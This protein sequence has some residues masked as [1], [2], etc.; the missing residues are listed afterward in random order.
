MKVTISGDLKK[1]LD[2]ETVLAGKAIRRGVEAAGK[3]VQDELR[4]QVAGGGFASSR[5]LSNAWRL[6]V[7]SSSGGSSL[8]PAAMIYTQAPDIID[9]FERGAP[10]RAR[11]TKY[12]AWPTPLN[13]ARG[14]RNA[15]SRGGVRVSLMEMAHA[16]GESAVIRTKRAGLSLWCLRVREARGRSR[17]GAKFNKSRVRLFVGGRNVEILT[18]RIKAGDRKQR[19]ADLISRGYAPMYFL[20]KQVS[21]RKRLDVAGAF[22]RA[23]SILETSLRASL[24]A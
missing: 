23:S 9:A 18:G 7:Y 2:E 1:M 24:A 4:Q 14:R 12:L 15:G 16:K 5:S 20:A 10:I 8:R 19:A 11:G 22:A 3:L 21:V 17:V 13:A 6:K